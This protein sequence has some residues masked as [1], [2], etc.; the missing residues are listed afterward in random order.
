MN[1]NR[2]LATAAFAFLAASTAAHAA[3][4]DPDGEWMDTRRHLALNS[5]PANSEAIAHLNYAKITCRTKTG[6]TD[7]RTA[8]RKA[9]AIK[10]PE[11]ASGGKGRRDNPGVVAIVA[12]VANGGDR[13]GDG[14]AKVDDGRAT[15]APSGEGPGRARRRRRRVASAGLTAEEIADLLA[16]GSA[17]PCERMGQTADAPRYD[18]ERALRLKSEGGHGIAQRRA[19]RPR[20]PT[21]SQRAG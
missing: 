1:M 11:G 17:S 8:R 15:E 9:A 20:R 21:T 2:I 14:G 6:S 13:Q 10:P 12:G 5:M 16:P 4:Y 19:H 7:G 18:V 3:Y